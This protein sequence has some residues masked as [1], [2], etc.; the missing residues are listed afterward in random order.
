MPAKIPYVCNAQIV[1][2]L[3]SYVK[4]QQKHLTN[5]KISLYW[6]RQNHIEGDA[7]MKNNQ[8]I[9]TLALRSKGM[10]VMGC[11]LSASIGKVCPFPIQIYH[12]VLIYTHL[13]LAVSDYVRAFGFTCFGRECRCGKQPFIWVLGKNKLIRVAASVA[14]Y[15]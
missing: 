4:N 1:N 3:Q 10:A 8:T 5:E 11:L 2:E 7:A 9:T 13:R 14:S 15:S 6:L 12:N